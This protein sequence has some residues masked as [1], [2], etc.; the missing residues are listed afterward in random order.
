MSKIA[1][2]FPGQGA[3]KVGMGR[4]WAERSAA[5]R[6]TFEEADEALGEPLSR[7]CWE[8]PEEELGLT[9]N[10]QPAILTA[11]LAALRGLGEEEGLELTA[12][13]VAGHSLGEYSALVAAGALDFADAVRLVRRRGELMQRAVPP[14]VGAMAAILAMSA[15]EVAAVVADVAADAADGEVVT[16][17]N[18][19][20]PGQ[21]VIAGH[22]APVAR[23]CELARERGA[24]KAT[25]LDV[26]APFHSPLMAPAR[27][28]MEPH[29]AATALGDPRVPVVVN[30]DARPVTTAA[31]ARDALMRQIDGPV[32]WV[33][34]VEHM[35]RALGIGLFLEIGPGT[36]LTGTI[37]RIVSDARTL[38]LGEPKNLDKLRELLAGEPAPKEA[39]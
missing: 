10:T 17:A 36:V 13:A 2:V 37:K 6:R 14:G 15:E 11:S 25:L 3:Q 23:A 7:L 19:N 39:E 24:K 29:L 9:A 27:A 12:A 26:S 1:F 4:E 5:A 34:S 16:V 31:A 18:Y 33:E 8:G 30:V 21:T 28:G 38:A 20:A 22:A 32:R 35:E